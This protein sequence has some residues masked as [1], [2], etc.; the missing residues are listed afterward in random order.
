MLKVIFFWENSTPE[1]LLSNNRWIV[2][3][4]STLFS[5]A[6]LM[7]ERWLLPAH[8]SNSEEDLRLKKRPSNKPCNTSKACW[9]SWRHFLL[10]LPSSG[11]TFFVKLWFSLQEIVTKV[12]DK[13]KKEHMVLAA[14]LRFLYVHVSQNTA[15][16]RNRE[17]TPA[18]EF[19]DWEISLCNTPGQDG[20]TCSV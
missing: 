5:M 16:Y 20:L 9:K 8:I 6:A 19:K 10:L 17:E 14:D 2:M 15:F 18:N 1:S 4:C 13:K 11:H 3:I 7:F 12:E